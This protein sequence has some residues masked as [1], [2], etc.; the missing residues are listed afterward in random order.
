MGFRPYPRESQGVKRKNIDQHRFLT[1]SIF[2][3]RMFFIGKGL[4]FRRD[5]KRQEQATYAVTCSCQ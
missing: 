4:N 2:R 3:N 5:L 1:R